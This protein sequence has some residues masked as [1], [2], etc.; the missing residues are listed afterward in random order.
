MAKILVVDDEIGIRELLRTTLTMKGHEVVSVPTPKQALALIFQTPLDLVI[1]DMDIA[2]ESG[3]DVL[4]K[5]RESNKKLPVV[6]YSGTITAD[7]EKEARSAGA[8]EVLRKD[9]EITQLT[10]QIDKILKAEARVIGTGAVKM[11]E[12]SILIVDDEAGIRSMLKTFFTAKGYKASE[13]A[14]GED[15]LK[16]AASEKFSVVLLDINMPGIDGLV[17]LKKLLAIDPKLGIVMATSET[18]DEKVKMAVESGA[19]GY[20]LKP[21][22]FLYLELVVMAKLAIADNG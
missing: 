15:A 7:I 19:Y 16:L 3:M 14:S 2:G 1:L 8:T 5:I 13:A 10:G 18:N 12:K 17:A 9:I 22:D 6:I 20:V 21:F 11:K 4:K